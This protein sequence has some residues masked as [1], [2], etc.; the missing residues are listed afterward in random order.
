MRLFV[1]A[2]ASLLL[3][4]CAQTTRIDDAQITKSL[5]QQKTGVAL[6][7]IGGGHPICT[8]DI[9]ARE[10]DA[11]RRVKHVVIANKRDEAPVA[12]MELPP[13]EYHLTMLFCHTATNQ[14]VFLGD[15]MSIGTSSTS[16]AS[17]SVGPGEVVNV[18]AIRFVPLRISSNFLYRTLHVDLVVNDWS[19]D[20][21]ENFRQKRPQLYSNMRTRL[22]S[23]TSRKQLTPEVVHEK[24]KEIRKLKAEG[25]LQNVP[26]V[27]N[28][29]AVGP[30]TPGGLHFVPPAG[31]AKKGFKA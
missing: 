26:A 9:S 16:Y 10:N 13:G 22:M 20:D 19:L 24:C 14:K 11:F 3:A 23:V 15:M 12:E 1:S 2:L 30:T 29:P 6:L 18:G 17:F 25:K 21:I 4:G 7:K 27:C 31:I 8:A 5:A 28:A